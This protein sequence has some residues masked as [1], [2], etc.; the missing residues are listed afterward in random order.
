MLAETHSDQLLL[1]YDAIIIGEARERT[2]NIDFL[3][4]ICRRLLDVRTDLRL[5]ITSATL[6]TEKFSRAFGNAPVI[7]VKQQKLVP[8]TAGTWYQR[9]Q[10]PG[11]PAP[12]ALPTR[13]I[14]DRIKACGG[15]AETGRTRKKAAGRPCVVGGPPAFFP[16]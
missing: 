3:L 15:Q 6:D 13:L 12:S 8:G 7:E 1:E 16:P 14:D 5:I 4:D 2:L 10:V 9:Y 11:L